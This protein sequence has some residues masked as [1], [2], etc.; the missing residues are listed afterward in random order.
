MS[1]PPPPLLHPQ[2]P[3]GDAAVIPGVDTP[4]EETST[5]G[6]QTSKSSGRIEVPD[7]DDKGGTDVK[8]SVAMHK[9]SREKGGS[10]REV[11]FMKTAAVESPN[12]AA[13]ANLMNGAEIP[14]EPEAV[15]AN[16]DGPFFIA[17]M[18]MCPSTMHEVA[19]TFCAKPEP[20]CCRRRPESPAKDVVVFPEKG[21]K[22]EE[23]TTFIET[24]QGLIIRSTVDAQRAGRSRPTLL[25]TAAMSHRFRDNMM[26]HAMSFRFKESK[27]IGKGGQKGGQRGG[28][29]ERTIRSSAKV[30]GVSSKSEVVA[31]DC[32]PT[33]KFHWKSKRDHNVA[34][35]KATDLRGCSLS[36]NLNLSPHQEKERDVCRCECAKD[37][38]CVA[39]V[40][41]PWGTMLKSSAKVV[42]RGNFNTWIK[43][44][45]IGRESVPE[46][47]K[48][49]AAVSE[50]AEESGVPDGCR[51]RTETDA[52]KPPLRDGMTIALKGGR[53]GKWCADEGGTIKCD[54]GAIG[55][56]EK[57]T[58]QLIGK[59]QIALQG[60]RHSKWCADDGGTIKCDRGAVQGWER[61]TYQLIGTHTIVLQGGKNHKWCADDRTLFGGSIIRCNRGAIGKWEKFT[62]KDLSEKKPRFRETMMVTSGNS[63]RFKQSQ[64]FGGLFRKGGREKNEAKLQEKARADKIRLEAE[65]KK[66]QQEDDLCTDKPEGWK[67][68]SG[69][70]CSKYKEN[71][72]CN[73]DGSYGEGWNPAYVNFAKWAANGIDATAACC[74]C[75]GGTRTPLASVDA[76]K[77]GAGANNGKAHD[78]EI[79]DKP[80]CCDDAGKAAS[81]AM[82]TKEATDAKEAT[83]QLAASPAGS[84]SEDED[85]AAA[86]KQDEKDALEEQVRKAAP[87]GSPM[88]F[89]VTVGAC[90][91]NMDKVSMGLCAASAAKAQ[92]LMAQ[93]PK[94]TNQEMAK[95][96]R[97]ASVKKKKEKQQEDEK[98]NGA[99]VVEEPEMDPPSAKVEKEN[100]DGSA[101]ASTKS[102]T[103]KRYH[104]RPMDRRDQ[105][106]KRREEK[107]RKKVELRKKNAAIMAAGG[108]GGPQ[109]QGGGT[110]GGDPDGPTVKVVEGEGGAGGAVAFL[111]SGMSKRKG[112]G[113]A[114]DEMTKSQTVH[115]VESDEIIGRERS[116]IKMYVE[117]FQSKKFAK[118]IIMAER[119]MPLQKDLK[120]ALEGS[121]HLSGGNLKVDYS[122]MCAVWEVIEG[123]IKG[124]LG[125]ICT[126]CQAVES[127][128]TGAVSR[129][130]D[131]QPSGCSGAKLETMGKR[132]RD[133]T[134]YLGDHGGPLLVG[135]NSNIPAPYS[136]GQTKGYTA[137]IYQISLASQDTSL[138]KSVNMAFLF[139]K[140]KGSDGLKL[141]KSV[142]DNRLSAAMTANYKRTYERALIIVDSCH[143]AGLLRLFLHDRKEYRNQAKKSGKVSRDWP[144]ATPVGETFV[145]SPETAGSRFGIPI[146]ATK[147]GKPY[148]PDGATST[149]GMFSKCTSAA[150]CT[151]VW[152]NKDGLSEA[153]KVCVSETGC[154]ADDVQVRIVKL[155]NVIGMSAT[156]EKKSSEGPAAEDGADETAD[157]G[158]LGSFFSN[159]LLNALGEEKTS[160][161]T[162]DSL[163]K[164]LKGIRDENKAAIMG[165]ANGSGAQKAKGNASPQLYGAD[166][167]KE[168]DPT[169]FG[170]SPNTFWAKFRSVQHTGDVGGETLE[171]SC[172]KVTQTVGDKCTFDTKQCGRAVQLTYPDRKSN[173]FYK[174]EIPAGMRIGSSGTACTSAAKY[175]FVDS[176]PASDAKFRETGLEL[177]GTPLAALKWSRREIEA[178][179]EE[180]EGGDPLIRNAASASAGSGGALGYGWREPAPA[181]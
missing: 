180:E 135:K 24:S 140:D 171:G 90:P 59:Q 137:G 161:D 7:D 131:E 167:A 2:P 142:F 16:K 81:E 163:F 120:E 75:G 41:H 78:V 67:S 9:T 172:I 29:K 44:D 116:V 162:F 26:Q 114:E 11:R 125:Q 69:A 89:K 117:L 55:T 70:P 168:M 134:L 12:I 36:G 54:R 49:G 100:D 43:G 174:S 158:T 42:R 98:K 130:W 38:K 108:G 118:I 176:D 157:I 105:R 147:A 143:S 99:A 73:P 6:K 51:L 101:P 68:S 124:D 106:E 8:A 97:N 112:E 21:A 146:E 177:I 129:T 104:L 47:A 1:L 86:K 45:P 91:S 61:F 88:D 56:W 150:D 20:V 19:M 87:G 25:P 159:G 17:K 60:G 111:V 141:H 148:T 5:E 122:H 166:E 48:D 144:V 27:K 133:F 34:G 110:K 119:D 15:L 30:A 173:M 132:A 58:I 79:A 66:G 62:F 102:L 46:I 18:G 179:E 35:D 77:C 3:P 4:P 178:R 164:R 32:H 64:Q 155:P 52:E 95:K 82:E 126:K 121:P 85:E 22:E 37:D 170:L 93:P 63:F 103:V 83:A 113:G 65:A 33:Q 152:G 136:N 128:P 138:D 10:V 94:L 14:P 127:K 169:D 160:Y 156:G 53:S 57:F 149:Y 115:K 28:Q 39:V 74:V 151:V 23:P 123:V 13:S 80:Y 72:W 76:T 84:E 145:Y 71:K 96:K 154:K 92:E 40:F 165:D 181:G 175:K 107:R 139:G 109:T 31:E 153:E 50:G